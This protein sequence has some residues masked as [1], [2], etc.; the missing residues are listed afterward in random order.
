MELRSYALIAGKRISTFPFS[1][2]PSRNRG[3][4]PSLTLVLIFGGKKCHVKT[5]IF[6]NCGFSRRFIWPISQSQIIIVIV[7]SEYHDLY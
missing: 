5:N 3:K 1:R 6:Q 7:Y 4:E 2:A